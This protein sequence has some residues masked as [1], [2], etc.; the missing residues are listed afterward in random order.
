[1]SQNK[2]RFTVDSDV[3]FVLFV[4]VMK[5]RLKIMLISL[6]WWFL[7]GVVIFIGI[8][9]CLLAYYAWPVAMDSVGERLDFP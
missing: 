5:S 3:V 8:W 2:C 6:A 7:I 1:M 9:L 4:L